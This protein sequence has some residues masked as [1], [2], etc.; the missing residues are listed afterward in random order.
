LKPLRRGRTWLA[1]WLLAIVALVVVCL[2]PGS[3]LPQLSVSDKLEHALAFLLLSSGAVQLFL[4]GKPLA[5][6][7]LGLLALGVAIELAQAL[8]TTS[9]MMEAG[10]VAADAVGVAIGI[11]CA[12]TPLKDVLLRI[13][14]R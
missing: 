6:V 1:L 3:D 9:R 2:L 11:A 13:D 4:R 5:I 12:W 14:P 8:L 7:V 10:D